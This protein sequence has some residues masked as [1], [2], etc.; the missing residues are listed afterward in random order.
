MISFDEFNKILA[1]SIADKE[2]AKAEPA[3]L[4]LVCRAKPPKYSVHCAECSGVIKFV[5]SVDAF[6]APHFTGSRQICDPPPLNTDIDVVVCFPT[7][8][9]TYDEQFKVIQEVEAFGF[10][11]HVQSGAS[12]DEANYDGDFI[13]STWRKGDYNLIIVSCPEYLTRWRFATRAAAGLNLLRKEDRIFL[14]RMIRDQNPLSDFP[15]GRVERPSPDW[16][17]PL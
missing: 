10:T 5:W 8:K 14:F 2:A 13:H 3:D 12:K 1:Q 17:G 11:Q 6:G 7:E 4:C 15:A 9:Q 16:W